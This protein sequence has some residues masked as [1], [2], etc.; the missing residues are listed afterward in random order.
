MSAQPSPATGRSETDINRVDIAEIAARL[1]RQ[2]GI[3]RVPD[4]VDDEGRERLEEIQSPHTGA[5]DQSETKVA[6]AH[7]AALLLLERI[8][9][10]GGITD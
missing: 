8:Q 9:E 3:V 6:S 1:P 7:K 10:V 5:I 4:G 2:D